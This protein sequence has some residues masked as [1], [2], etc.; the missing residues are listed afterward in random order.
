MTATTAAR[1]PAW[2]TLEA[3]L[4][5]R[6]AVQLNYHG[7]QRI[8]SPHALGWKNK[9]A[10]LLAY[11]TASQDPPGDPRKQWRNL[12]VDEIADADFADAA[13]TWETADNYNAKHPFN[14][15]DQLA[16]AI[17]DNGPHTPSR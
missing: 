9:K 15:I 5:Q 6:R 10:M 1:P 17:T 14:A 8:V 4:R 3:A 11:Q 2:D 13:T 16:I 12:F 7:R